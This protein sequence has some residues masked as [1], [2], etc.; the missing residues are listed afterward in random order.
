MTTG[1]VSLSGVS[2]GPGTIETAIL[3]VAPPKDFE[4]FSSC[5]LA[6]GDPFTGVITPTASSPFFLAG[7]LHIHLGMEES[8]T[9]KS[10]TCLAI[11]IE[12]TNVNQ[13][14]KLP[15]GSLMVDVVELERDMTC[16]PSRRGVLPHSSRYRNEDCV[17]TMKQVIPS[18]H[19]SW[20]P[21]EV[22]LLLKLRRDEQRSWSEAD[23]KRSI[24][25][26]S[27]MVFDLLSI[28]CL[29]IVL[30]LVCLFSYC[31]CSLTGMGE[32]ERYCPATS[33]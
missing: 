1:G 8:S 13:T 11:Y 17:Q 3:T 19:R 23:L 20:S 10:T 33:S 21:G 4:V 5:V 32:Y 24:S 29:S 16:T 31:C 14:T 26:R 27:S 18:Q 6:P 28:A 7:S 15:I 9:S 30:S 12:R 22:N 25:S 2:P